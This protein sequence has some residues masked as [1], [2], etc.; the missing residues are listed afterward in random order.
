MDG[1]W[2]VELLH[3]LAKFGCSLDT[4][5]RIIPFPL[6]MD[7]EVFVG[8]TIFSEEAHMRDTLGCQLKDW[9]SKSLDEEDLSA[10]LGERVFGGIN[11]CW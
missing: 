9:V 1:K 4:E 7:V 2:D 3:V 10:R 8:W 5:S 11:T 6:N